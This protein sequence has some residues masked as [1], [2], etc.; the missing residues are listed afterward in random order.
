MH[1]LNLFFTYGLPSCVS[2]KFVYFLS[3]YFSLNVLRNEKVVSAENRT[4]LC[5]TTPHF[6]SLRILRTACRH[7]KNETRPVPGCKKICPDYP[8]GF[9][10][11]LFILHLQPSLELNC[12]PITVYSQYILLSWFSFE[13]LLLSYIKAHLIAYNFPEPPARHI[14]IHTLHFVSTSSFLVFLE[15]QRVFRTI[16]QFFSIFYFAPFSYP[17]TSIL[18]SQS[19]S[20]MLCRFTILM[21]FTWTFLS[22]KGIQSTTVSI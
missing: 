6:L 11:Y 12:L 18:F 10:W 5:S 13:L 21:A 16:V 19:L 17:L 22:W 7:L 9:L 8:A 15:T 4:T 20:F 1:P 3:S 14:H 2:L